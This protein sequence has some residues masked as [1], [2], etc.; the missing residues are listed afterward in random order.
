LKKI[1]AIKLPKLDEDIKYPASWLNGKKSRTFWSCR[2]LMYRI[3]L[4]STEIAQ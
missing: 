4:L 3:L 1:P 2:A